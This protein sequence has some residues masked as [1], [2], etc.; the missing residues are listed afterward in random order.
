MNSIVLWLVK[1]QFKG[2]REHVYR[3]LENGLVHSGTKKQ[4]LFAETFKRWAA[5]DAKRGKLIAYAYRG[6]QK[7]LEGGKSLSEALAPFIPLE[8]ML[9]IQAGERGVV[10]K[11][12]KPKIA[13]AIESARRQ[14]VAGDEMRKAVNGAMAEPITQLIVFFVT[15]MIYGAFIWPEML[16]SFPIEFWPSWTT[17]IIHLQV[18]A[19]GNWTFLSG[20]IVLAGLYYWALPNWTGSLRKY[21]EMAPPFSIYRDRMASALLGV[22]GGLLHGGLTLEESLKRIEARSTPYLKW[23]VRRM[24]RLLNGKDPMRALGTGLFSQA[25][26][27]RIEDAAS[28]RAFDETLTHMGREALSSIIDVVK[29]AAYA[30]NVIIISLIAILFLYQTAVQVF[31]VQDAADNYMTRLAAGSSIVR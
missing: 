31:G 9:T 11:G 4:E 20:L 24:I 5:R 15:S 14:K 13:L 22:L 2:Y 29:R 8:E 28:S 7:R 3:A 26:L 19:A 25:V 1:R 23:H 6:I 27:D 30:A 10:Q 16:T 12:D 17:P 21:L 18:W